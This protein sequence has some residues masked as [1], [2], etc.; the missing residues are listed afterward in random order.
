MEKRFSVIVS[1]YNIENYIE[2]AI[3]SILEQTYTNYELIIINDA[4][5]D[6]TLEKI[7]KYDDPRI[8]VISNEK[9]RGLGAVRNIGIERA[10]G[11]YI[12][13]LDGDDALYEETTL[14]KINDLI[15][16]DKKYS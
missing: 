9:N 13:H 16:E 2:R 7:K 3:N 1:A 11:E 8:T 5:K 6:S 4:S 15:G 12:V 14:Q 10:S